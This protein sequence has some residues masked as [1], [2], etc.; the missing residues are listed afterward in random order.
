ARGLLTTYSYDALNRNITMAYS[1]G[2][3]SIERHYDGAVLG[4]GRFHF[5]YS[6]GNFSSGSNV[7]HM[8]IDSYDAVGRA[9]TGRQAFKTN[10][11]WSQNF[12]SQR[13]YDLTGHITSQT[14]PSGPT[15]NYTY[16]TGGK[17]S[18]A[19]RN[20]GGPSYACPD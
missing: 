15:V 8:T 7:E 2:T 4:K 14:Y 19:G 20:L 5:N 9:L 10:G 1:D 11:I 12:S 3:P 13:A 17:L 6:G 18:S 16:K